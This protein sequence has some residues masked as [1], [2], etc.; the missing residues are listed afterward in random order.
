MNFLTDIFNKDYYF[1]LGK[2]RNTFQK[3]FEYTESLNKKNVTILETGIARQENNWEGDGMSTLM[4]D[5][6]IN[7]VG[8]NFTSIDINPQ[9][10]E[11]A[12]S[13]VSAKSNLICS[14]SVIKL[15]EISRDENFPMI[16]VLYLDSF[17]VDFNNPVPS[18]FH[19]IK[20]LLAIF[21][22]I[23]KGTLIVVD[24]NFNG[25]GKGQMIKDYMKNIGINPFFDEY[26][27]GFIYE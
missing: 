4:F 16:D 3:I 1:K 20:E 2:R 10:V 6:Y 15:H 8:G 12:R 11:F 14:D 24:D 17:D 26:Q 9:N 25:K 19:H 18:S 5:R 22:K 7:S 23:Q 21:P 13:N 27:I